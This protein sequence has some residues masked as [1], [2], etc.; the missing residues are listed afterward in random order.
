MN[1]FFT[2]LFLLMAVP[3]NAEEINCDAEHAK[4]DTTCGA[5][6]SGCGD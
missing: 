2:I 3:L 1:I 5:F 4:V 6:A